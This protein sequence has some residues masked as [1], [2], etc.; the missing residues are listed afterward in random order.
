MTEVVK[1]VVRKEWQNIL[2]PVLVSKGFQP[3][4]TCGSIADILVP[5]HGIDCVKSVIID[6]SS[7][8]I[9]PPNWKDEFAKSKNGF[10]WNA[11]IILGDVPTQQTLDAF[12]SLQIQLFVSLSQSPSSPTSSPLFDSPSEDLKQ[13]LFCFLCETMEKCLNTFMIL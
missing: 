13:L 2:T 7:G 4:W 6:C 9:N 10:L 3:Q 8:E 11:Y 5:L 1:C 12:I